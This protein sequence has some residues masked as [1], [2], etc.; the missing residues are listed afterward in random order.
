VASKLTAQEHDRREWARL[1]RRARSAPK[2]ERE[3]TART[4]KTFVHRHLA[5]SLGDPELI[6]RVERL[7]FTVMR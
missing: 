2:G 6:Q 5:E 1:R 4:L 7:Q 3:T